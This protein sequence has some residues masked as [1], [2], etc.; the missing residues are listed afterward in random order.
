[1]ACTHCIRRILIVEWVRLGKD[2]M[3]G[4]EILTANFI[5]LINRVYNC[6]HTPSLQAL[7]KYARR[8][9]HFADYC[10]KRHRPKSGQFECHNTSRQSDDGHV[11]SL[12]FE[13][14]D[15]TAFVPRLK[16]SLGRLGERTWVEVNH[17]IRGPI[18]IRAVIAA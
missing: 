3:P 17:P 18:L 4:R 10:E 11:C 2:S 7:A 14:L 5:G 15:G 1:M 6:Y 13:G 16:W 9:Y 12:T 8:G